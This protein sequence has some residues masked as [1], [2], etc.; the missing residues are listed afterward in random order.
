MKKIIVLIFFMFFFAIPVSAE[1]YGVYYQ[2]AG[3][4][5]IDDNLDQ[6]VR[7]FFDEN[8][9]DAGQNDWVSK[10]TDKN[11]FSHIW[12]FVTGG[13]KTPFKSGALIACIIFLSAALSA[14]SSDTRFETAIYAAVLAVSAIVATDV[15][16]SISAAISAIKGCS[17]FMLGF[18]PIFATVL[19][20]SGKTVTAPAM[21]ALLLGASEA[22][23]YIASF[24][25]LPLMGGYLSISISSGVSPLIKGSGIAEGVKKF[26]MWVLSLSGTIF[27]GILGI[28]TA[29]NSAADTL[30]MRTAKFLLGVVPIAGNLLSEA[31]STVSASMGLLK[32]SVGL[33]GV[34]ALS[35]ILLPI[36]IEL[37]LW[38]CAL[39]INISLGEVFSL[40][41]I[42]TVLRAVDATL[43]VLLGVVLLIGGIF[44][45]SLS[46]VVMATK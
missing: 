44:I 25:V 30:S 43:A 4:E 16:Q 9:I 33:Y 7:E 37:L 26:S 23:S 14:F 35:F 27:I 34:I 10:L 36:I 6:S 46:V 12:Q 28:Q 31:A 8:G 40:P 39:M 24:V 3:G 29:V 13:A 19:A 11:V 1:D 22:I 32:S 41:K 5:A 42:T 45:I 21:S 2:N 15:W 38:R 18:I 20:L 17:I